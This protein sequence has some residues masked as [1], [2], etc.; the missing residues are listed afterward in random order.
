MPAQAE[1]AAAP[2]LSLPEESGA[3]ERGYVTASLLNCRSAPAEPLVRFLQGDHV[4]IDFVQ[5]IQ[6]ALR[7]PA[8]VG[9]D[10]LAHIVAGYGDR[11]CSGHDCGNPA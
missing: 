1:D 3:E 8:P 9:A 5:H 4:G 11:R 2:L 7:V 6:H 10:G